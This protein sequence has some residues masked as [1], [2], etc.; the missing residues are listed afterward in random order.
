MLS[1][2]TIAEP[3]R[4][5]RQRPRREQER[6]R[7]RQAAEA[8]QRLRAAGVTPGRAAA[9]L[10]IPA[11]TLRSWKPPAREADRPA[12]WRGRPCKNAPPER[13]GEVLLELRKRGP[14]A[15]IPWLKQTFP[16]VARGELV[17]LKAADRERRRAGRAKFAH[18]LKWQQAGAVWAIDYAEPPAPVDGRHGTIVSVRDLASGLQLAWLPVAAATADATIAVLEDLFREHG[19]PLVLKA[20]NGSPFIAE[21]TRALLA[22][23]NVLP[24]YSPRYTPQ[25]NGA[26]EAGIGGLKSRTRYLAD[27][28]AVDAWTSAHLE[29]ARRM[30]NEEHYPRRLKGRTAAEVWRDREPISEEERRRFRDAVD[31]LH[32]SIFATSTSTIEARDRARLASLDRKA[33][34]EALVEMGVLSIL[35]SVVTPTIKPL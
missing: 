3:A 9:C 24:L 31:R 21:R 22:R 35:R 17:E 4:G 11:S 10:G 32:R 18:R 25:Y 26:C 34:P 5:A 14:H 12:A 20:D 2:P 6:N 8:A 13:R 33:V 16:D 1:A 15:G 23:W 28:D 27:Y 30:A 7:R 19:P 29:A